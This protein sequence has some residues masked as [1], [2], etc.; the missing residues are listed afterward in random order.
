MI[1]RP[2][3]S[4]SAVL[5]RA[6]SGNIASE[7]QKVGL[8]TAMASEPG[9]YFVDMIKAALG[10]A[11]EKNQAVGESGKDAAAEVGVVE[12]VAVHALRKQQAGDWTNSVKDQMRIE[13]VE[14][15]FQKMK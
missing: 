4:V 1:V 5:T 7:E 10:I 11:I 15:M 3:A 2:L 14:E 6:G 13:L 9:Y 12:E 8:E